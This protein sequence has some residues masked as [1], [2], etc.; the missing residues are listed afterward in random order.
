MGQETD[1]DVLWWAETIFM[2]SGEMEKLFSFFLGGVIS[3]EL[4]ITWIYYSEIRVK[5][6]HDRWLQQF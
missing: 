2:S 3:L 4:L 1:D 6:Q 5:T